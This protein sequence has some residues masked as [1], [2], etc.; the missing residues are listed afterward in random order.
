MKTNARILTSSDVEA[1][2]AL[3]LEALRSAP[4]AFG[5][6]AEEEATYSLEQVTQR[7]TGSLP[8]NPTFGAFLDGELVGVVGIHRSL[9]P[10]TRHRAMVWGM[11]V[12]PKAR[13]HGISKML[14]AELI[15]YAKTMPHLEELVLSV[16]V[17][18]EAAKRAYLKM[19]FET[20]CVEPR[21]LKLDGVYYD[22]EWMCLRF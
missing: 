20:Y 19:G 10:K 1:Y 14:M 6:S 9:R 22:V 5:S 11:Y 15:A 4:T 3:R 17:G 16:T 18:N 2:Q 13:G 21:Y 7:I 12:A 8:E